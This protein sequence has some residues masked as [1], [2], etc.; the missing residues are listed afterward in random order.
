MSR[1]AILQQTIVDW[2]PEGITV[3]HMQK[4]IDN[5]QRI[6]DITLTG[7]LIAS[8]DAKTTQQKLDSL[9]KQFPPK[10]VVNVP[11]LII[12]SQTG[13]NA[14]GI[15]VA[16]LNQDV[17]TL[18][19]IF[20][21]YGTNFSNLTAEQ[22]SHLSAQNQVLLASIGESQTRLA[23][24][25]ILTGD[26]A[27]LL[28]TQ[29]LT[30]VQA[31]KIA[32]DFYAIG[33]KSGDLPARTQTFYQQYLASLDTATDAI[34]KTKLNLTSMGPIQTQEM[35]VTAANIV[36]KQQSLLG[37]IFGW[38]AKGGPVQGGKAIVVG[39]KGPEI[40]V[41]KTAGDI[42]PNHLTGYFNGTVG[43]YN[44]SERATIDRGRSFDF[45]PWI[46]QTNTSIVNGFQQVNTSLLQGN[47]TSLGILGN[48]TQM[49][50][51]QAV[52]AEAIPKVED[53][54]VKGVVEVLYE[55]KHMGTQLDMIRE[56][57]HYDQFQAIHY[58]QQLVVLTASGV[59]NSGI[60]SAHGTGTGSSTPNTTVGPNAVPSATGT[61]V[62]VN[63]S[64]FGIPHLVWKNIIQGSPWFKVAVDNVGAVLRGEWGPNAFYQWMPE[65]ALPAAATGGFV[66]KTGVAVIHKGETVTPEGQV[67]NVT[68]TNY[69]NVLVN[70]K[71]D[72]KYLED[73][74]GRKYYGSY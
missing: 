45:T 21:S 8:A 41:P 57:F 52:T 35:T 37:S 18:D 4:T 10:I 30:T 26:Y 60:T 71:T 74:L 61:P 54:V 62:L 12:A 19:Q 39:E 55:N 68:I 5:L 13:E 16:G 29:G 25:K 23:N 11:E 64:I 7:E 73:M 51:T 32:D 47:T 46:N 49:K 33:E 22:K 6:A 3:E 14:P 27:F 17:L 70:N 31:M 28:D 40:F 56:M 42:V 34:S 59:S 58:L 9:T 20:E 50:V 67:G 72:E 69:N 48:T 38:A 66:A 36:I 15:D 43:D 53:G 63:R 24:E 2:G 65:S 1:Q 44:Q